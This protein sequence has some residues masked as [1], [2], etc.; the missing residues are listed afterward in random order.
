MTTGYPQYGGLAGS[1]TAGYPAVGN[2][3]QNLTSVSPQYN[4]GGVGSGEPGVR[5]TGGGGG[6]GFYYGGNTAEGGRGAPGVVIVRWT[7]PNTDSPVVGMMRYNTEGGFM[8]VYNGTIWTPVKKTVVSF[9]ATGASMFKVP[10]GVTNVD[11]LVVA[12]GGSGG[13]LGGGGGAGGHIYLTNQPVAPGS[14]VPIYVGAG[15]QSDNIAPWYAPRRGQPSRF[16]GIEAYG[17]GAGEIHSS[18]NNSYPYPNPWPFPGGAGAS[19]G[20]SGGG[21]GHTHPGGYG[22]GVLGQGYPGGDASSPVVGF[23]GG[24]G[25][26]GAGT[27]MLSPAPTSGP[28][29]SGVATSITG[30]SVIRAGGGG[31]GNHN[32]YNGNVAGSGGPGGGGGGGTSNGTGNSY[33]RYGVYQQAGDTYAHPGQANTG[34]GGGGGGHTSSNP[35]GIGGDGG[36]GI[37]IVRY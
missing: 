29:G 17:G 7:N 18:N 19:S 30:T 26:G 25:A 1:P 32:G 31:G 12:G 24:G 6:G 16:G 3:N 22:L 2:N 36:P 14:S 15:G 20:G 4:W 11:V 23:G 10:P 28:G 35:Y 9:T 8:E 13:I 27:S 5:N 21:A 33:Y 37:V 34:G